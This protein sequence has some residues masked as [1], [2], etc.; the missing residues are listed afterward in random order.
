M[1]QNLEELL[2]K[3]DLNARKWS[4]LYQGSRD[5]FRSYDFHSH[6]DNKPNTLTFVKSTSGNIFGGFTTVKWKSPLAGPWQED[7]KAFIFSLLN[8]ENKSILFEHNSSSIYSIGSFKQY[9]SIFG[10]GH[11]INISDSSNTNTN[12]YSNLGHTYTHPDYN[13]GSEKARTIL[14]GTQYFQVQEIEVF[15]MQQ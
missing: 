9:S 8:K 4:L 12:S 14:A 11:D 13:Y 7:K 6:S 1:S 10:G 15:Q 2:K 5:G 3:K